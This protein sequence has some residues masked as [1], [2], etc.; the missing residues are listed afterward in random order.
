MLYAKSNIG[1]VVGLGKSYLRL[2]EHGPEKSNDLRI[3]FIRLAVA[4]TKIRMYGISSFKIIIEKVNFVI[5]AL[6]TSW[7]LLFP[8]GNAQRAGR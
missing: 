2:C 4:F 6:K 1:K 3:N 8:I 5:T 7:T